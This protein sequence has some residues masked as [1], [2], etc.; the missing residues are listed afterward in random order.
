MKNQ[1]SVRE[2][3][4][5]EELRWVPS[6]RILK[7]LNSHWA[8][9]IWRF[10]QVANMKWLKQ[11]GTWWKTFCSTISFCSG[12]EVT[13]TKI[14]WTGL[15]SYQLIPIKLSSEKVTLLLTSILSSREKLRL[16]NGPQEKGLKLSQEEIVLAIWVSITKLQGQQLQLR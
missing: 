7:E 14:L 5:L 1:W 10:W 12:P 4:K 8:T 3:L 6:R 13:Q 16:V 9:K 11:T 2:Q 15:K